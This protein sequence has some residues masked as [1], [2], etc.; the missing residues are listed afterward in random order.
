MDLTERNTFD[1]AVYL[2]SANDYSGDLTPTVAMKLQNSLLGGDAWTTQTEVKL[3]VD[4]F[5]TWV[6]LSFDFSAV[7]DR[8]DYDQVVIQFGGEG[9]FVPGQF[10]FDDI[11][12]LGTI[13]IFEE[14]FTQINVYPNPVSD[15]LYLGNADNLK[16]VSIYSLTGQLIYQSDDVNN[17]INV[18]DY[19]SGMY[20]LRANGIDGLQYRSK[21]MV[22]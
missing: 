10:Y 20:M 14:T 7:A 13:G 15:V 1:L 22:K 16:N 21:F 5:D 2:P 6:T 9:H 3:T 18:S 19:P 4:Q 11:Q 17:S 12:L 8:E